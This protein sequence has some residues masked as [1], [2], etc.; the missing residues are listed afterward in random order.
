MVLKL[1]VS[2]EHEN[3]PRQDVPNTPPPPPQDM[4]HAAGQH[5]ETKASTY[6]A[7]EHADVDAE[8]IPWTGEFDRSVPKNRMRSVLLFRFQVAIKTPKI[9]MLLTRF[10]FFFTLDAITSRSKQ[11]TIFTFKAFAPRAVSKANRKQCGRKKK[12][13]AENQNEP[14]LVQ[15]SDF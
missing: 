9:N 13:K 8:Y 11:V 12:K 6:R 15:P 5:R 1:F 14:S 3:E 7:S 10:F 4:L 2:F